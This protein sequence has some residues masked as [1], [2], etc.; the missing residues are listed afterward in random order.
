MEAGNRSN[1]VCDTH[2]SCD[3]QRIVCRGLCVWKYVEQSCVLCV[4]LVAGRPSPG[5]RRNIRLFI[6]IVYVELR[7]TERTK[8]SKYDV[9]VF[10]YYNMKRTNCS[11]ILRNV[12]KTLTLQRGVTGT[13]RHSVNIT[14]RGV[15]SPARMLHALTHSSIS[16]QVREQM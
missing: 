8:S 14:C 5:L 3:S 7:E 16:R 6:C 12:W 9:K 1:E 10:M 13:A 15:T 2:K 11:H 4:D